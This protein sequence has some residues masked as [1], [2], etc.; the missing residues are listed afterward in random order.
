MYKAKK[1]KELGVFQ[2]ACESNKV[3]SIYPSLEYESQTIDNITKIEALRLHN[4]LSIFSN[5]YVNT[6]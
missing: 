2:V 3:T 6:Y 1:R 4:H 5:V